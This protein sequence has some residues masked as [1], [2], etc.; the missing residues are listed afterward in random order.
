MTILCPATKPT[1][2]VINR[3]WMEVEHA[4]SDKFLPRRVLFAVAGHSNH[5]KSAHVSCFKQDIR[6]STIRS[7]SSPAG[8]LPTSCRY[9]SIH[10]GRLGRFDAHD[11]QD[12][13]STRLNSRHLGISYHVFC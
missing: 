8:W 2:N 6:Q 11:D 13:K 1:S 9:P 12:R 10:F 4:S 3:T 5:I 7:D